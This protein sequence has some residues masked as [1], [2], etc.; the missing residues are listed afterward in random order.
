[1]RKS[2]TIKYMVNKKPVSSVVWLQDVT[3]EADATGAVVLQVYVDVTGKPVTTVN[4]DGIEQ[5]TA[6]IYQ[7]T[8]AYIDMNTYS[9]LQKLGLV[10][11]A[12]NGKVY[13]KLV[14]DVLNPTVDE[15]DSWL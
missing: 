4:N 15:F 8:Y 9:A 12:P 13:V 10:K 6:N 7:S 5:V 1:M 2:S 14:F 3:E 11:T